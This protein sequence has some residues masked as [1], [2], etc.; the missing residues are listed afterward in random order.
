MSDLL[1]KFLARPETVDILVEFGRHVKAK[2]A[3][4]IFAAAYCELLR[5]T[6]DELRQT[7]TGVILFASSRTWEE[8]QELL[9]GRV[10]E[11]DRDALGTPEAKV[12]YETWLKMVTA[13]VKNYY[14]HFMEGQEP[15][16]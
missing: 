13:Q 16:L 9:L 14:D 5:S 2:V 11:D 12:F 6:D 15:G 7:S 4:A 3:P 1:K 10:N 8:M